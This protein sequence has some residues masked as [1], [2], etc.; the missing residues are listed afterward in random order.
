LIRRTNTDSGDGKRLV[1]RRILDDQQGVEILIQGDSQDKRAAMSVL[2]NSLTVAKADVRDSIMG[3]GA[4][5]TL[6]SIAQWGKKNSK[7]DAASI[8]K[9]LAKYDVDST[10]RDAIVAAG[11][12]APL[13]ALLSNRDSRVQANSAGALAVLGSGTCWD[14]NTQ[15]AD[16]SDTLRDAQH[17]DAIVA[18]GALPG[19]I[20]L[21]RHGE[22]KAQIASAR[23]LAGLATGQSDTCTSRRDVIVDS[24]AVASLVTLLQLQN[25]AEAG[26]AAAAAALCGLA[27]DSV[28]RRKD[29]IV[30]AGAVTPLVALVSSGSEAGRANAESAIAGLAMGRDISAASRKAAIVDAGGVVVNV[31]T[32]RRSSGA[33][34]RNATSDGKNKDNSC[35]VIA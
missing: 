32:R 24:R 8:L 3:Y 26:K 10:R 25:G 35:C 31:S 27:S 29:A 16:F 33:S 22:S 21:L 28:T 17:K 7:A 14:D 4:V 6:V 2:A 23:A 34:A 11:A 13:V 5:E 12:V 18:A 19:L 1:V 20:R 9:E 30:A 15:V